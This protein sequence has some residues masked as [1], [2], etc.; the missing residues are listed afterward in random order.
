MANNVGTL[1]IQP[2]RPQS[3]EDTFPSAIANEI[4]GGYHIQYTLD[5]RDNIPE[6]RRENGMLC[7]VVSEDKIYILKNDVWEE[8]SLG[9]IGEIPDEYL[10]IDEAD[11]LYQVINHRHDTLYQPISHTHVWSDLVLNEYNKLSGSKLQHIADVPSYLQNQ[12]KYLRVNSQGTG[13][14]WANISIGLSDLN[15]APPNIYAETIPGS[16]E[17]I[18]AGKYLRIRTDGV[19]QWELVDINITGLEN[20]QDDLL[21]YYG[22]D[23]NTILTSNDFNQPNGVPQLDNT[24]KIPTSLIPASLLSTKVVSTYSELQQIDSP[25]EGM[26]AFTLDTNKEYIY[27][28]TEWVEIIS[29]INVVV[30]WNNITNRPNSTPQQIDTQVTRSHTHSNKNIL[31]AIEIPFTSQLQTKLSSIE[32]GAISK[33]TQDTLYKPINWQ[34]S[35]SDIIDINITNI[36]KNHQ[37]VWDTVSGKFVNK[38]IFLKSE[39]DSDNDG[40]VDRSK[41]SD[42]ANTLDSKPQSYF[43][44]NI[45][46]SADDPTLGYVIVDNDLWIDISNP[47][48]YK[49]KIY[50]NNK[51]NDI[52]SD[53]KQEIL[54]MID[55]NTIISENNILKVNQSQLE[56]T[57][58]QIS[59][60]AHKHNTSDIIITSNYQFV[61]QSEKDYW[62]S[63]Q[64]KNGELQSNL[65]AEFLKGQTLNDTQPQSQDILWSSYKIQTT[66][67]NLN[68]GI[69]WKRE[70]IDIINEPP[71]SPNLN[72]SYIIGSNPIGEFAGYQNYIQIYDGTQWQFT[73]PQ[74][75]EQRFVVNKHSAYVYTGNEWS[76]IL[77]SI[78]SHNELSELQG[79]NST[80]SEF[81]HL[82][83]NQYQKI[84]SGYNTDDITEGNN[85]YFTV[86]RQREQISQISPLQYNIET[87]E[88]SILPSSPIQDGYMSKQDKQ[89]LDY[90][91]IGTPSNNYQL[92]WDTNQNKY[93]PKNINTQISISF[94]DLIDTPNT[95]V[96]NNNKVLVVDE[97]NNRIIFKDLSLNMIPELSGFS[98]N[99]IQMSI[100]NSHT[101]SDTVFGILDDLETNYTS[102]KNKL[103][104]IEYGANKYVHPATHP[105]S[106]IET[107]PEL[108]FVTD[109]QIQMWNEKQDK[110]NYIPENIQ[111]RGVANGYA[112]LD[113]NGYVPVTQIP[114]SVRSVTVVQT[115]ADRDAIQNKFDGLRVF[116]ID[117]YDDTGNH[118]SIEY[119]WSV[120]QSSW[121]RVTSTYSVELSWNNITGKPNSTPQQID[122]Q[123]TRS[124]THNSSL[125]DIDDA[126]TKRHIH[127]NKQVLDQIPLHTNVKNKVLYVDNTGNIIW[128]T[129]ELGTK[130]I[131]ESNIADGYALVYNAN[132]DKIVYSPMIT[133]WSQL[134][135]TNSSIKDIEDIEDYSNHQNKLVIVNSTQSGYTYT[136]VIDGGTW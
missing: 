53:V 65:N 58:S 62:N 129:Q 17:L 26:R 43:Q 90:I 134:D 82:S 113:G 51:W 70:V 109:Y 16:G 28:G 76:T 83:Y 30:D 116:V 86:D 33:Q 32:A 128:K 27:T 61:T 123:V 34:P 97:P 85:Q 10:T 114:P 44:K 68:Y 91:N 121:V 1:V 125:T 127:S 45:Y 122:T 59:D 118:E 60:F 23:P 18:N 96:A 57:K 49:L 19:P 7:Y 21:I 102:M 81:Y 6:D 89:K 105:A 132:L 75:S 2:I 67:G 41:L 130:Q 29:T 40:V 72:D 12:N 103:D 56:I 119:I 95:F 124:H 13:I 126:V 107:T 64:D 69:I 93:T 25:Y 31:D 104:S 111:N 112:S 24:A 94:K 5:D 36:S 101:H 35:I 88:L 110:L 99:D 39:L 80:T 9:G 120:N 22:I 14:E 133:T 135:K 48:Q 78:T 73:Q 108:R 55:D 50:K 131:D 47:N 106:I 100:A 46:K 15:D 20:K 98:V 115:I 63:K 4:K 71:L 66:F 84:I 136:N 74:I 8:L 52:T 117:Q 77:V 37:L 38:A 79:G 11:Q 87:G 54:D 42:N 92:M 3:E